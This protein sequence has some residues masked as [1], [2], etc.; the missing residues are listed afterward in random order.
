M[1]GR[2]GSEQTADECL[3]NQVNIL[4]K[5]TMFSVTCSFKFLDLFM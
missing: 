5:E 2:A 4:G 3:Y 1:E